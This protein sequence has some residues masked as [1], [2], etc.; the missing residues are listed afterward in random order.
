MESLLN[1][2]EVVC[3]PGRRHSQCKGPE[4]GENVVY[5]FSDAAGR[6]SRVQGRGDKVLTEQQ[7][8]G[9]AVWVS[10][11]ASSVFFS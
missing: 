2:E 10:G 8:C 9:P 6:K 1:R 5:P 4:A 3:I 11:T 7:G